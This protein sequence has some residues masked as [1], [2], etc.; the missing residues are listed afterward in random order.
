[1]DFVRLYADWPAFWAGPSACRWPEWSFRSRFESSVR[2]GLVFLGMLSTWR[3]WSAYI[4]R[5]APRA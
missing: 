1:M 3:T 2:Q 4:A 5:R